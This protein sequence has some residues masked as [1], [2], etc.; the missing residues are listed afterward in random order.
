MLLIEIFYWFFLFWKIT[1]KYVSLKLVLV[2]KGLIN[3]L[4]LHSSRQRQL[5]QLTGECIDHGLHCYRVSTRPWI[6]RFRRSQEIGHLF[7]QKGID[8]TNIGDSMF[9]FIIA[10]LKG[11]ASTDQGLLLSSPWTKIRYRSPSMLEGVPW[12][13]GS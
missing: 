6:F 12:S 4:P 11:T 3:P 10:A 2:A 9:G 1:I 7:I 13:T 8:K 5:G